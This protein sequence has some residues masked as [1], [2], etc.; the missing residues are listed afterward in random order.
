[1][2]DR[3]ITFE[4][5]TELTLG[6]VLRA[7]ESRKLP[8]GPIIFGIIWTPELGSRISPAAKPRARRRAS[9]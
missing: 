1:M 4:E 6:G 3:K 9:R 7:I 2:D 5:F 8:P